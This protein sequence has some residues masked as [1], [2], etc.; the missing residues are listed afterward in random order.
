MKLKKLS[1]VYLI[2]SMGTALFAS[3]NSCF[4]VS[5]DKAVW[6]KFG[7]QYPATYVFR[8]EGATPNWVVK[9]RDAGAS[10]WTFVEK[11]TQENFFNGI[12]CARLDQST[13][14]LYVSVGFKGSHAKE[15]ECT[16]FGSVVFEGMS[17]YYDHRKAAFTLSNDNWGCNPWGHPGAPWR[18]PTDDESDNYQAALH[19]CRSFHLPLSIA[20]NSRSAGSNDMWKIMQQE[21]DRYDLS[22]EP[23]VHG[24]THPKNADGYKTNGYHNEIMGCRED[25]LKHLKNIPY[26]QYVVEHILTC[27][28][29]DDEIQRIDDGEFIFLRGFNWL[30][31]P[32]SNDYVPWNTK[33]RFYGIGGLN[34]KGYDRW[35]ESREPKGRYYAADVANANAIFDRV[36][37]MG[38]IFYG[39]WHPDRFKNSV[40]YDPRPGVEGKEGSTLMHHLA[41]VANRKDVWYVANGWLYCYRYVAEHVKVTPAKP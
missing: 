31:N 40:I 30:D 29:E 35:L 22:W 33:Y 6:E 17:K 5:I 27:G 39:L 21:L 23:A 11:R 3:G 25:I 2:V 28:Y 13:G 18:G 15:I 41:Y 16:G 19:V 10:D 32:D 4:T 36:Y 37:Q 1:A 20:I 26:G 34:T 14:K 8:V 9:H 12:E 24:W 7:F 38:G